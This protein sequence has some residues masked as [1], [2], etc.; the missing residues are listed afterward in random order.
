MY[1]EVANVDWQNSIWV[2]RNQNRLAQIKLSSVFNTANHVLL[3]VPLT[4]K[5][6]AW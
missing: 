6:L 4:T 2:N 3:P 5:V 1:T